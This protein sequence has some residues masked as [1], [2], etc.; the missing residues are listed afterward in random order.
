LYAVQS[1][2]TFFLLI[3]VQQMT[4]IFLSDGLCLHMGE[5]FLLAT[6]IR[7]IFF[8]FV[9][10]FI[11]ADRETDIL[12]DIL[13][14]LKIYKMAHKMAQQIKALVP[15]LVTWVQVLELTQWKE[16]TNSHKLSLDL[17]THTT[18]HVDLT[19][20]PPTHTRAHTHTEPHTHEQMYALNR[21]SK[22]L[23]RQLK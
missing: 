13:V 1:L 4:R 16:R 22:T 12:Q 7:G 14:V 15:R 23:I 19:P 17:H 21:C 20:P 10:I 3:Y 9:L 18:T 6:R 2:T 8:Y 11:F 5:R